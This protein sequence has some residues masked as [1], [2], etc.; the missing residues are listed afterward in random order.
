M[1]KVLIIL[2]FLPHYYLKMRARGWVHKQGKLKKTSRVMLTH[3]VFLSKINILK[4]KNL[5]NFNSYE[6][7]FTHRRGNQVIKMSWLLLLPSTLPNLALS[8]PFPRSSLLA[9]PPRYLSAFLSLPL[10]SSTA[11]APH[12][13]YPLS[14]SFLCL[15][16][17]RRRE[18]P[19][20]DCGSFPLPP[21]LA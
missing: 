1:V 18:A 11:P 14:L 20:R 16:I 8:C 21:T 7:L 13:P 15:S 17:R 10:Y 5:L 9:S 19:Q 12:P 2:F 4:E 6:S 3:T